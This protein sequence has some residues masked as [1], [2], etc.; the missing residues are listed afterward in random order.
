MRKSSNEK[1]AEFSD[2]RERIELLPR[3]EI[4]I[5]KQV[6]NGNVNTGNVTYNISIENLITA[7]SEE[8]ETRKSKKKSCLERLKEIHVGFKI[9]AVLIG[10]VITLSPFIPKIVA[11]TLESTGR[12]ETGITTET[13]STPAKVK[14]TNSLI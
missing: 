4:K 8:D 9:L 5:D 3:N 7:D 12:D 13:T 1:E 10:I 2:K 14:F 6:I 11:G